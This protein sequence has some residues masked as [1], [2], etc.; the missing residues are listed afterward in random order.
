MASNMKYKYL[1]LIVI[2]VLF[3]PLVTNY[4]VTR[5]KLWDYLIAGEPKD[6]MFFWISYLSSLASFAMVY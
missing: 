2:L 6:W 1:I 4:L 5:N 3:L